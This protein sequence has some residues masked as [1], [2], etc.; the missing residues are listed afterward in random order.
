[1]PKGGGAIRGIGEKFAVNPVTGTGSLTVPIAS[2]PG[3]S[4]FGPQL[5]LSYD[6]GSG[7]GPFGL[8]FTLNLPAITRKTD[9]GLPRYLDEEES[10][11]F[12]LAGAEDL[13]PVLDDAL[14]RV[15]FERTVHGVLYVIHRYRPR[16]EGLF[17]RIERWVAKDTG[18]SHWRTISR[19]NVTSL[20][21]IDDESRV[22]SP[23]DPRRIFSYLLARTFD[24]KGNLCVYRYVAE[25]GAG[26]VTTHANERNRTPK[27][28]AVQRYLK[29]VQY[30]H[31]RPYY[32][33]YD[34]VG[35]ATELPPTWFFELVFD[36]GDHTAATPT[37]RP[38]A[39]WPVRPDPFSKY[40]AGFEVRTY[41][42]CRRVLMF[43]H[44]PLE[45]EVGADC[46]VRSTNI[47]Y[48]DD[49]PP[50]D[51][52][53][54]LYSLVRSVQQTG[55]RRKDGSYLQRSLPP[56]EF[57]YTE[58][59]IHP[60][61]RILDVESLAG[62]PAGTGGGYQFADLDGDGLP[63][64]LT[65]L[66]AGAWGFKRNLSP[67]NQVARSDGT[68]VTRAQFG[69]LEPV[70][71]IPSH[72]ELGGT[73]RLMDLSGDGE[74]D[75][76]A[77][78]GP[79]PGFFERTEDE[80]WQ[81]FRAFTSLPQ[82][83]WSDPD[84]KFVDLIGDGFADVLVTEDDVFT[85]YR[86]RGAEG[87]DPARSVRTE[88]DE[89]RGP[90]TVH[91]DDT[92]SI[93]LAD[94]SGDGLSDLVRIRN[95]EV[96]YW[97]NL[98]Y[99]RFGAKVTMDRAPRFGSVEDFDPKRIRLADVDGSGTTDLLY[100]GKDG[101][102]VCFNQS[103]NAWAE[104]RTL[105]VFPSDDALGSVQPT[106][107]LG[108][109]TAC[110]VWSTSLPEVS[111]GAL[112]YVDLMG[113][114]KPHLMIR[115]RNNLGAET[116]LSYAPSTKF[117]LAD[118]LAGKP[119]IT[120]LPHVVHVLERVETYDFIG[121]SRFVTRYAYHHGH[122][123]G[124]E[125]EFRG[126]GMVEQWDTEEFRAAT[127]FPEA[128][129]WDQASWSPPALTKTWFHTGVVLEAVALSKQY[130]HE[131]WV[132]PALPGQERRA[133]RDPT[134]LPDSVLPE[135]L[136]PQEIRE[137][138][139]AL[140]G[141]AL[142]T[143][144]YGQDGSERAGNPY[145]V[146]EQ[147]FAVRRVQA[148]G[149]NRHA[150]FFAHP[151]EQLTLD[152]E[153][154]PDDPRVTHE[155]TLEVDD[156]GDVLRSVAVGYP[157]RQGHPE[158][159]P[160][161]SDSFRTMLAYDQAR[162][163]VSCTAQ[164]FTNAIAAGH[165]IVDSSVLDTNR[166]PA[167]AGTIAYEWTGVQP[168]RHLTNAT[169]LFQFDE[170]DRAW[171]VLSDGSHDVPY[172][173]IPSSDIEGHPTSQA[174]MTR[175]MVQHLRT[176]YCADDL[177]GLL[178][179]GALGSLALPGETYHRALSP[180][181]VARIFGDRVTEAILLE[182]GYVRLEPDGDWWIPSGRTF[183]SDGDRD[184]PA[185][186]LAQARA[187]FF[188]NRRAVD[189]FGSVSRVSYDAYDLQPVSATDAVGST[190]LL[191]IDYRTIA[192]F[193]LTDPNGNRS[194][195]ALDALGFVAATAV[196][197]KVTETLG[198]DLVGFEP[199]LDPAVATKHL[200]DPFAQPGPILG[201]ASSRMI[202]DALAFFRTRHDPQPR[203]PVVYT[204]TR[205]THVSDLVP[206]ATSSIQHAYSY[207]D[208]FAR[209]VQ[210][211]VR[212]APGP[213]TGSDA[214]QATPIRWIGSGW[215]IF[216]N[217][218]RAVRTYEPFF[219][220][221]PA[222]EFARQNGVSTIA[223]YDALG[224]VVATLH[225]DNAWEKT[226][227]DNWR[228]ET[229][230]SNDTVLIADPRKDRDVGDHF[231]RALG[232]APGIFTS[233][234]DKRMG[235]GPD[236]AA[237]DADRRAA[238]IT[239][240]H[241]ATPAVEHFDSLGRT[242]LQIADNGAAGR[243][244]TRLALDTEGRPSAVFDA[245]GRRAF[246]FVLSEAPEA[247]PR[248][249]SGSDLAGNA[250]YQTGIDAGPRWRLA[251][252]TGDPLRSWDSRGFATRTEYDPV[253]RVIR[254]F[255]QPPAGKENLAERVVY[256]ESMSLESAAANVR[257]RAVLH[258]DGAGEQ[259][260]PRYDFHGNL[261]TSTRRLAT[262]YRETPDWTPLASL[263]DVAA[264][265]AAAG[266]LLDSETFT[267]TVTYDALS[268]VLS[269]T[270]PDSS[271]IIPSYNE[272]NQLARIDVR[273]RG[274]PTATPFLGSVEYNAKGQRLRVLYANGVTS[275]YDYDPNTFL[276]AHQRSVRATDQRR[277][278]D[279]AITY[280]AS[281]NI[282]TIANGS[283]AS[284]FFSG[285]NVVAG[286]RHYEYDAVYQLVRA[287][288]REHPSQPMPDA[289]DAVPSALPHP[290]D[291]Q[292]LRAYVESYQ[293]DSVG[294][295]LQV[296]HRAGGA[297]WTRS[298]RYGSDSNRL[299]QTSVP[300]DPDNGPY[301]ARYAYDTTG[302]MVAMPHVATATWNHA[303]R[304][305]TV[306]LGGG[307]KAYYVYDA[308][309]AR[310]RK[311][312]ERQG[313]LVEERIYLG[314]LEIYRRRSDA[315]VEDER[316]TLHIMD[317]A[318]RIA[319]AETATVGGDGAT[320][321]RYY[322]GDYLDSLSISLDEGGRL[323]EYEEYYPFG[324]TSFRSAA[325]ALE[326]SA[327][328]YRYVGKERDEETGLYLMG[329]RFYA[330]WLG[331]WTSSDT[332]GFGA[333]INTFVYVHNRPTTHVDPLGHDGWISDHLGPASPFGQWLSH[334]DYAGSSFLQDD[335]KLATAQHVAEG[336]VVVSLSVATGGAA[337]E[338]TA[339]V[340]AA[341]GATALET[342]VVSGAVSNV[343]AGV[344]ERATGTAFATGSVKESL[345]AAADPKEI[346]SDLATGAVMGAAA[347][348]LAKVGTAAVKAAA[349]RARA[350][351]GAAS[352]LAHGASTRARAA[353][354]AAKEAVADAARAVETAL[355]P[356][357]VTPEGIEIAA[358]ELEQST[359][360]FM[361][362]LKK[363]AT[364]AA[365]SVGGRAK[366]A[367]TDF[368]KYL[369][370]HIGPPPKGMPDPHAHHVLFK[371]GLGGAQKKLVKKGQAI[372]RKVGIDPIMSLKNLVWA[373]NRVKGQHGIAALRKVVDT[374][375]EL[376]KAGAV[377]EDYIE[378]L[379]KLGRAAARRR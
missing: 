110:L 174:V 374:L 169:N 251:R 244:A 15:V 108:N 14:K 165:A 357:F 38:D 198:D 320:R 184:P 2:S 342:A 147:N 223:F 307:G 368:G 318:R 216:D 222:F 152:Y 305:V 5:A 119:W 367:A 100:V 261:V 235:A 294:N 321:L 48:S 332:A 193:L 361:S 333:G 302:N 179:V 359:T 271:V 287:A 177:S 284:L 295:I 207:S 337:A 66:G 111:G 308:S 349:P 113:G 23:D 360:S 225:P 356:R 366:A 61:V 319:V 340:M 17:A 354:G 156:F 80:Q 301:S 358:S 255:V 275:V 272:A 195:V 107:L 226:A 262:S 65:D 76:V 168:V 299:Q 25:D 82:L 19:D 99:G 289:N 327:R 90:R 53:K 250:L 211:K 218:G 254:V 286:D 259:A 142:R 353:I 263:T 73:Q 26:I 217:K 317:G 161:L 280:D 363:G 154:R 256:G 309:G 206:G 213:L 120:H 283:D 191:A 260:F 334:A 27:E 266:P 267:T 306:D 39:P 144:V 146:V 350:L 47:G 326:T 117:Y 315:S 72:H 324:A 190:T 231:V 362:S 162:L 31:G 56:L 101:V 135:G 172:E 51:P 7:N 219:S 74:L 42:R 127:E 77:L 323:I 28:R 160:T 239:E 189:P 249:V 203:P 208:G 78:D 204:M 253:H 163:H 212:A 187:H 9:K 378:A 265:Q 369:T 3:R 124:F 370:K 296:A 121:R 134:Q 116:R 238:K 16:I 54:P 35:V 55:Y 83:N 92:Q 234:H 181:H 291:A 153:R 372:L 125:R 167:P 194:Q 228:R 115:T 229:W 237:A 141:M 34:P 252:V 96:C 57:D 21:G 46:L 44:F 12:I 114:Q 377:Q 233:W 373:P 13:V 136:G 330:A 346:A 149:P 138:A 24:D 230:D 109:G 150:S 371:E 343:A 11:T 293:Y 236:A 199:D 68:T 97:P 59:Q 328:R 4:G 197:G 151:R 240:A 338:A 257:G 310:L 322:L 133:D 20:F 352:D 173:E 274:S 91:S 29:S 43:H 166:T 188:F 376:K 205:E 58:V 122:F 88:W 281:A 290:N 258:Y 87:F 232:D 215:T 277:L 132:E 85:F 8:G 148:L 182:G 86:S 201:N 183:Y 64:L 95:G 143:E 210:K 316:Q 180:R 126:F 331:R 18:L 344:V 379:K 300:G 98:G 22:A 348:G 63:S 157:R 214:N 273:L 227:F 6:S 185:V 178:P 313:A 75:V 104:P 248:Y 128:T 375:V 158:P 30:G 364:S 224:R 347:H 268:R 112:R 278:Q 325:G 164:T 170:L 341:E 298:Y 192:P 186:E 345:K 243:Y 247:V 131:Y 50:V 67:L 202:Y 312:I 70:R 335:K 123:D 288:G 93:V 40:R 36:Y 314:G 171:R 129:N 282:T 365:R 130:Q 176:R 52:E 84:L 242:C 41:R 45:K 270:A 137:A 159:E 118:K 339:G 245:Q 200:S 220:A 269:T 336:V 209:E 106:D 62:L 155:V 355:S 246:E 175:R 49:A 1:L 105:A 311:V 33:T 292:A 79:V 60:E 196:M 221:T 89:E 81:P 304:M 37:P 10:D 94:M 279:L 329:A 139:R 103:G 285:A 241:A 264:I 276:L 71:S 69:P 102:V 32:A 140:K 303:N 351:V 145:H 297:G